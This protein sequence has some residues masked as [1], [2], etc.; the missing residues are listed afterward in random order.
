MSL[1]KLEAVQK[2]YAGPPRGRVVLSETTLEIEAGELVVVWGLKGSG[3]STLLRIAAGIEAPDSGTV[4]F[5]GR[6]LA[7][8]GEDLLGGGLGYCERTF[9]CAEGQGVL[10]QVTVGLLA[11]G[12]PPRQ[13]RLRAQRALE[14]AGAD[15]YATQRLGSLDVGESV[16]VAVARTLALEPALLVV[17]EPTRGVDLLERDGI[18]AL[19]RSLADEGIAVLASTAESTGLAGADRGLVLNEGELRGA[20]PAELATVLPLRRAAAWRATG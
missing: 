5:E 19:L 7:T 16:R 15:G 11:R 2:R 17:D 12:V 6:D 13:A 4:R 8:H 3:R 18:L 1:L 20:P 14:R 10:E 9:R